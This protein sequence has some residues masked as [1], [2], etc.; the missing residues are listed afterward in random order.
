MVLAL[1]GDPGS[2]SPSCHHL[3]G[4]GS[5]SQTL[6]HPRCRRMASGMQCSVF[7]R[8]GSR[9][10]PPAQAGA[11]GNAALL[12]GSSRMHGWTCSPRGEG[13]CFILLRATPPSTGL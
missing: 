5:A 4:A 12:Q 7:P 8:Q 9:R 6:E 11:A 13:C 2:L 1:V 3:C 10:H